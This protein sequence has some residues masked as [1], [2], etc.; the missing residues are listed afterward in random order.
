MTSWPGC[1]PR[2]SPTSPSPSSLAASWPGRSGHS[3]LDLW[4][5]EIT[6]TGK[7]RKTRAVVVSV[8]LGTLGAVG[9]CAWQL[10][11]HTTQAGQGPITRS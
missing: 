9:W 10:A 7:G 2:T 3:D 6:V 1:S 4:N 11:W 5:R 8:P